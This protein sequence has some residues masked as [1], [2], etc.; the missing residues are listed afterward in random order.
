VIT[1]STLLFGDSSY[2][3]RF[4]NLIVGALMVFVLYAF[5][6]R[7][8]GST[9]WATI[10][11][12]MLVFDGFHFVQS[13]IA[14]PEITV[15]F[16]S[17]TTLYAFYRFWLARQIRIAASLE[18]TPWTVQGITFVAGT[19]LA[20]LL[21][22]LLT[23]GQ[24]AAAHAVAFCYFELGVWLLVRVVVPRVLRVASETS[25]AEGSA[26]AN[27]TLTAFDGGRIAAKGS[28]VAGEATRAQ[29]GDAVLTYDDA[30][31]TIA[32]KRDGSAAYDTP[33]GM[34]TFDPTGSAT[35]GR[36]RIDARDGT[37]WMWL[38][39]LSS[40]CLAASKWNGLF[41][42][43]VVFGLVLAVAAQ[44][45]WT[46]VLR[47]A[48]L[49]AKFRAALWGNPRGFSVDIV[50]ATI[51]LVSASV[52]AL[53]YIPY[54]RLGHNLAALVQ[55]QQ[56]MFGY[57]YDLHATH[58][59]SS[60]WWQWP[61]LE[62]PISYYY[63]DFRSGAAS[64]LG[65]A[66]CVAEIMALPNPIVWWLG[67]FSVP[68][69]AYLGWRERNKG[70]ILLTVAYFLQWLPWIASPRI[71]FEYHF[72]P[73]LA[74]IVLADG[75]LL[76]RVW[77]LRAGLVQALRWPRIAVGAYLA[78]VFLAFVFWYPVLAGTPTSY[79]AWHARMF[80]GVMGQLW[81]NPHPGE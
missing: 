24:S 68:L 30:P 80:S 18:R 44:R 38:L 58:P 20:V 63:K 33:E 6:K 7:L 57:H 67:L 77:N 52:Y 21:S 17:L 8:L 55:L 49:N 78:A 41:D 3:W 62:V 53:S 59:Y 47:A 48:G 42:F 76:Q 45:Y 16:F 65:S 79:D 75:I 56:G 71:A 69:M 9:L 25:Y 13:R 66:C 60:K 35:I 12:G 51:L 22:L 74:V 31:L 81:I 40:G 34:L 50:I 70:Y 2:G 73:N 46:P 4:D 61:L 39:A 37:L 15:A 5:A 27:G 72:F 26:F 14:T 36:A 43:F 10:C 1:L 19:A 23:S 32:Y 64:S 28:I 54:F 11:A 29:K